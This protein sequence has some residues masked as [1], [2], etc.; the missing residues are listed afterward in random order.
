MRK[1]ERRWKS[2]DVGQKWNEERGE[3]EGGKKWNREGE[4]KVE[5][6]C[7]EE[8]R[9]WNEKEKR[10]KDRGEDEGEKAE[11]EEIQKERKVR[12]KRNEGGEERR[13]GD[14]ADAEEE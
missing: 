8:R 2:R 6:R 13:R 12:E 1:E 11:V 4:I 7:G 9:G 14:D 10:G 3:E 5:E